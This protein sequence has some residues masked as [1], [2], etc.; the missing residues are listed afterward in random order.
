[1]R[2]MD[3]VIIHFVGKCL[4]FYVDDIQI[5][6]ISWDEHLQQIQQV[7][8]TLRHHKICLNLEKCSFAMNTI[9]YLGDVIDLASQ[10]AFESTQ[11]IY[12]S[13]GNGPLQEKFMN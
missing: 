12:K 3:D 2:Y 11:K 6:S 8:N 9:K 7:L 1:M 10:H 5:F 4:I 13:L